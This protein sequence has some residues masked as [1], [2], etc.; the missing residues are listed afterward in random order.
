MSVT[1]AFVAKVFFM[2]LAI[3]ANTFSNSSVSVAEWAYDFSSVALVAIWFVKNDAISFA[4]SPKP[5]AY[6][7]AFI[8]LDFNA[9]AVSSATSD[10]LFWLPDSWT[11]LQLESVSTLSFCPLPHNVL[12]LP[13]KYVGSPSDNRIIIFVSAVDEANWFF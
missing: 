11:T 7:S 9:V 4:L 8:G 3:F 12:F 2:S 1:V 6:I 10:G 5:I 13:M